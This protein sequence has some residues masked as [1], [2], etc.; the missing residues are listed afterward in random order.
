MLLH[1][2]KLLMA[3]PLRRRLGASQ[4]ACVVDADAGYAE[5]HL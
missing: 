3:N 2:T 1:D 4:F 5:K